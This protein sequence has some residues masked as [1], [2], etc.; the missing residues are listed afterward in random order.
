MK[1]VGPRWPLQ[2]GFAERYR[3]SR[4]SHIAVIVVQ[5]TTRA[6]G[7]LIVVLSTN[8]EL[9]KAG[10]AAADAI[11]VCVDVSNENV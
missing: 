5:K 11:G 8:G 9:V 6:G 10:G 3:H 7:V 4:S 1:L 2:L